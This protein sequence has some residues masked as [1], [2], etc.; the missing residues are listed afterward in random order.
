MKTKLNDKQER[1]CQ[2]YLVDLNGTQAA[3]RAGYSQRT[4]RSIANEN[5]T[6]PDIKKRIQ[7]LKAD[8]ENRSELNSDYVIQELLSIAKDDIKNYISASQIKGKVQIVLKDINN[9]DTKNISELSLDAKGRFKIKLYSRESAL[10]Q[11]GRHFGIFEDKLSIRADLQE[12]LKEITESGLVT[13]D[14][15]R[16]LA[17]LI[18]EKQKLINAK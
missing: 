13:D 15:I 16:R 11:L 2:E 1:F 12:A 17:E 4:A 18:I 6:K 5:L 3:I 8:K 7:Q 10:V 9:I 14:H